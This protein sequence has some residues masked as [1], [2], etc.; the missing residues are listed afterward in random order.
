MVA[1]VAGHNLRIGDAVKLTIDQIEGA[2]LRLY[3]Q[4]TGVHVCGVLPD[5]V[6]KALQTIPRVNDRNFFWSGVRN[7]ET[8]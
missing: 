3:A 7:L 6:V 8:A 5:F 2:R 1:V 4:K